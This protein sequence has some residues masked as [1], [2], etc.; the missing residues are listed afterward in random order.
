MYSTT[1]EVLQIPEYDHLLATLHLIG[2]I[3]RRQDTMICH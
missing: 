2:C 1:S 3:T